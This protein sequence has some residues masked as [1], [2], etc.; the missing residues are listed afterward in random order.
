M[1]RRKLFCIYLKPPKA[2]KK[3]PEQ[4]HRLSIWDPNYRTRPKI[5]LTEVQ[6]IERVRPNLQGKEIV[7]KKSF[8]RQRPAEGKINNLMIEFVLFVNYDGSLSVI[9]L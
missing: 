9:K 1:I 3:K 7:V 2:S 8:H 4:L 5:E 6:N